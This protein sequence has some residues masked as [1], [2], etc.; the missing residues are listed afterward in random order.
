MCKEEVKMKRIVR[1]CLELFIVAGLV[2]IFVTGRFETLTEIY[3]SLTDGFEYTSEYRVNAVQYVDEDFYFSKLTDNQKKI[4]SSIAKATKELLNEVV[5]NK[6]KIKSIED[7]SNDAKV[8]IN[9]FLCD[10]PEVFYLDSKYT[11]SLSESI[12]GDVLKLQLTYSVNGIEELNNKIKELE[13]EVDYIIQK[14]GE[15]SEY[16]KELYIHDYLARKIK[17]YDEYNE[18]SSDKYHNAYSALVDR[19][20]V[21]DR[22]IKSISAYNVKTWQ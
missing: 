14:A 7:A 13:T 22:N 3:Q 10:H 6:Y 21:C 15:G 16:E 18:D 17:Y 20:A 1:I 5:V 11:I 8:A 9:A 2:F 12:L 19:E 4:Y